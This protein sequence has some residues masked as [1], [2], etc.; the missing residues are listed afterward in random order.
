MAGQRALIAVALVSTLAIAGCGGAAATSGGPTA[1][2]SVAL[3]PTTA[4]TPRPSAR[5]TPRPTPRPSPTP[6]PTPVVP[7][8]EGEAAKA[9]FV[10]F[11]GS[12]RIP[13]HLDMASKITVL[14]VALTLRLT[15]DVAGNG[16]VAGVAAAKAGDTTKTVELVVVDGREYARL[17]GQ[18]WARVEGEPTTS[19]PLGALPLDKVAWMGLDTVEGARLH[20]L[21]IDDPTVVSASNGDDGTLTDLEIESGVMDVWVTDKGTPVLAKFQIAGTGIA[22]SV[23]APFTIVGRYDFSDVGKPVKVQAP[24]D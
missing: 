16:D 19:D 18:P 11:A 17:P 7:T 22:R 2:P 6:A 23:R 14:E 21:R 10:K 3:A 8:P 24:I 4:P 20:H 12:D 5:P 13:F 15:L 1:A 9:G